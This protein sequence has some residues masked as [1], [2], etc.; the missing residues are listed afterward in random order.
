MLNIRGGSPELKQPPHKERKRTPSLSEEE[1]LDSEY[2][3]ERS[4]EEQRR[5]RRRDYHK[6]SSRNSKKKDRGK[7]K[8]FSRD[9]SK[10]KKNEAPIRDTQNICMYNLQGKCHK[11]RLPLS[12]LNF[13]L[14]YIY[15]QGDDCPFSHDMMLPM[16]ME[17]CKFYLMDCCAKG[18]KCLYMHSEFPCKYYH[19]GLQCYS[20]DDCKFAHGKPLSDGK[21]ITA[22]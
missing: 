4:T 2:S 21:Y 22:G 18:D 13:Y 3:S 15:P 1:S 19:T 14:T 7:E 6:K 11:V 20:G 17:L 16:K 12:L 9:R 8:Q 10:E 5:E